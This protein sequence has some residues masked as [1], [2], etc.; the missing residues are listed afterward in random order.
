MTD[1][2]LVTGGAGFVGRALVEALL[3]AGERV[4][5]LD[6]DPRRL[7]GLTIDAITGSVTDPEMCARALSPT[8]DGGVRSVFHLAGHAQLWAPDESVFDQVNFGGT[9]TMLQAARRA[10]V[11]EFVHCSSLTTLVGRQTPIGPSHADE[12]VTHPHDE[13][14]GPYPRSKWRADD[15]VLAA[16]HDAMAV[17]IAIPTEPLGAG[18]ELLTPPSRMMVDFINGNTPAYIDCVLNFVP[19]TALAQGL[20]AVRDKGAAGERYLLA[21]ENL[22][23]KSLLDQLEV[24]TG[25]RMPTVKMPYSVALIAGL[26]ETKLVSS[27]TGQPPKAPLTGVRL[28]G[29]QVSFSNTKAQQELGWQA[30]SFEAALDAFLAWAKAAGHIA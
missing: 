20:M 17:K 16:A 5:V 12:S 4:R 8:A 25:R 1:I 26:V 30:G 11:K 14:L 29:R 7:S 24:R 10:G 21:G 23:L 13:M 18:D 6:I 19:V 22:S 3:S 9:Q 28:A 15:V 2:T 27:L